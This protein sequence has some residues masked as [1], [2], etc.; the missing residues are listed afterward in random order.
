[1]KL[2]EKIAYMKGLLDGMELDGSTKEGKAILQM[3][4]VMEEMGVYIDDLQSQVDELTELCDLLDHDLGDVESDL[5]CDDDDEREFSD[6]DDEEDDDEDF[7]IGQVLPADYDDYAYEDDDEEEFDEVQYVVNC[8]SCDETVSLS[9]R[10]LEEGSMVCPHCG[11]L[12]EFNYDNIETEFSAEADEDADD[13]E[14]E[15]SGDAE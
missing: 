5:Y 9:E 12:L 15:D 11:E 10:Q 13:A 14:T 6:D 1:M 8:P 2:T 4:E 7:E 3:A